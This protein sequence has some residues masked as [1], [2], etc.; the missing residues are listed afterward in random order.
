MSLYINTNVAAL[1]AANTLKRSDAGL[2][3]AM[4]RLSSGLR[5]NSAADDAAGSAISQVLTSQIR[6]VDQASRNAQDGI[7]LAQTAD[8]ALNGAQRMLHRVRELAVQYANG[9]LDTQDRM[10]IQ[11]EVDQ[12]MTQIEQVG[13]QAQFNGIHVLATA[14]SLS[15]QIGAGDGETISVATVS[16]GQLLSPMTGGG[17]FALSMSMPISAIDAAMQA[18]SAAA[19]EFGA[20]QNRL[21]Y[22]MSNLSNYSENLMSANSRI[23][24]VDMAFAASNMTKQQIL[25]Q[26]GVSMLTQAER[27]PQAVLS[28]LS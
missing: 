9:T 4:Q 1:D 5:I 25:E 10:S 27:A 15:F 21:E 14:S 8:G 2:Q 17:T 19:S 16:L 20:V 22:T 24:D 6:G 12:L 3:Q 18:T 7:S 26:S 11:S 23:K 13:S 28:L